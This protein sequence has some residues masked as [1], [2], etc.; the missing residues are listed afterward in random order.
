M[1]QIARLTAMYI[2]T[3]YKNLELICVM[4]VNFGK[5]KNTCNNEGA[6]LARGTIEKPEAL[7]AI[8]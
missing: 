4:D 6:K 3:T 1:V 2:I 8:P 7:A 5:A